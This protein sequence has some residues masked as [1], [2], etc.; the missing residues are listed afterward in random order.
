[1]KNLKNDQTLAGKNDLPEI[2]MTYNIPTF[3]GIQKTSDILDF[4]Q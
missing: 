2:M 1:M 3:P 4:R